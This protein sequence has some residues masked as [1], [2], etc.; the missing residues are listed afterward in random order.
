MVLFD[1]FEWRVCGSVD[2]IFRGNVRC[3]LCTIFSNI[4]YALLGI[5]DLRILLCCG[6]ER[7]NTYWRRL[8]FQ[9]PYRIWDL[10]MLFW[11]SL[12]GEQHYIFQ[13]FLD[14][15]NTKHERIQLHALCYYQ[16]NRG[17]GRLGNKNG[18]LHCVLEIVYRIF[19]WHKR[20]VS[21]IKMSLP[22]KQSIGMPRMKIV[23]RSASEIIR[24]QHAP[25]TFFEAA[26]AKKAVSHSSLFPKGIVNHVVL[27]T[28]FV[29]ATS[30][31]GARRCIDAAIFAR[32]GIKFHCCSL[33]SST[34]RLMTSDMEIPSSSARFSSHFICGLVKTME[35][36]MVFMWT[37][38]TL[39]I[40][41]VNL[42]SEL[43]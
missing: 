35:R 18:F 29:A 39:V 42:Y 36:C 24:L 40:P 5:L 14:F 1:A 19:C 20:L 38:Y 27:P 15:L 3:F 41:V 2:A 37:S 33:L 9:I 25:N 26:D 17:V 23:D 8:F 30:F 13:L 22:L 12:Y 43:V 31:A 34:R 10:R 32:I 28:S 7:C 4:F 11:P 21:W 16:P 6:N